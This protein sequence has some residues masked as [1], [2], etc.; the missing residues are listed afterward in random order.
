MDIVLYNTLS[1]CVLLRYAADR[2][3]LILLW[4]SSKC[5]QNLDKVHQ[6]FLFMPALK[7][8]ATP[9]TTRPRHICFL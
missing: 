9:V 6:T 8:L 3:G 7:H 5:T 2:G 1:W 4:G